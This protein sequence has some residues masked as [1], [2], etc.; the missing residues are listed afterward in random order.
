VT[1]K[2][3]EVRMSIKES[4][5]ETFPS[6]AVLRAG[7]VVADNAA[8]AGGGSGGLSR[9]GDLSYAGL[10]SGVS[11]LPPGHAST[12]HHHGDQATIVY[13]VNGAMTFVVE[14]PDGTEEFTA[15]A[16]DFAAIPAGAVHSERNPSVDEN[17]FCIVTRTGAVPVVVNL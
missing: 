13:I 14:G 7:G 6:G 16:G 11:E 5:L 4:E 8:E 9:G 1:L 3:E 17:C 2:E 15:Y 12:P 10:W